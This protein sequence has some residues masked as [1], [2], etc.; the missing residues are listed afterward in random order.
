MFYSWKGSGT[1]SAFFF[2]MES[3]RGLTVLCASRWQPCRCRGF[4]SVGEGLRSS[5]RSCSILQEHLGADFLCALEAQFEYL[6]S[7]TL[8][9]ASDPKISLV[10]V[11]ILLAP[12][13]EGPSCTIRC[14]MSN[15]N[16]TTQ[17]RYGISFFMLF[18]LLALS[19]RITTTF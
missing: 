1:I 18:M 13:C 16:P 5:R 15:S 19:C 10:F 8:Q 11:M 6:R 4:S 9:V 17:A 3:T 2:I 7:K 14:N 12:C